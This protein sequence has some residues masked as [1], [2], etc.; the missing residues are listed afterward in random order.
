MNNKNRYTKLILAVLLV[1]SPFFASASIITVSG[2]LFDELAGSTIDLQT[3]L[4]WRDMNLTIGRSQ[5]SVYQDIG[6]PSPAGCSSS[7]GLD[8][9][10]DADG[11]R[12]ANRTE[13]AALLSNW[14]GT[15]FSVVGTTTVDATN[16]QYFR[17]VFAGG[18]TVLRT[19]YESSS[20]N[21]LQALGL[22]SITN[23]TDSLISMEYLNG[24]INSSCCNQGSVLVRNAIVPEPASLLL[25][26][27]GLLGFGWRRLESKSW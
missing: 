25:F 20:S 1:I 8:L 21:P 15:T 18:G 14:F 5:C 6:G 16:N 2:N 10:D 24:N 9:I 23:G 27:L 22:Y 12:Y 17:D 19:D 4:E 7:D 3:N 13:V 11:W 26:G